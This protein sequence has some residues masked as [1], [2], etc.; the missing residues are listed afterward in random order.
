[1]FLTNYHTHC[2]FCDGKGTASEYFLQAQQRGLA[3]LGF[4][5]H[6]PLPFDNDFTIPNGELDKYL[7]TIRALKKKATVLGGPQV[8]LG[9]EIDF[10]PGVSAPA[11]P[12]WGPYGLDFKIGSVHA[13]RAPFGN[14][15]MLSVDGHH[16]EFRILWS[17]VYQENARLMARD[18]FARIAELCRQGGFDVLGHYDLIKKNNRAF[19]FLDESAPW[20]R[21]AA[22]DTLDAVANASVIL[23][24][25]TGGLARGA[26]KEIYPAPWLLK[27][28]CF[29][30]VP[31]QINAD[32]H[33]PEHVNFYFEE[34]LALVRAA[35]YNSVRILIDN[36]WQ[37]K[38]I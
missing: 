3:A 13:L 19:N 18:Y 8:Y 35:G 21:E 14:R 22:I 2:E 25:N 32:A 28:A 29:R 38:I 15:P 7:K 31:V 36:V 30:G 17:E 6:A 5:S 26:T 34:S 9:L 24:V 33:R 12:K 37:D 10:I 23:E 27:E 11:D 4:S 16:D 1:M 20:Y